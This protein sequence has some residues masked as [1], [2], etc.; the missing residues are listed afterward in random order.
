MVTKNTKKAYVVFAIFVAFVSFVI[1][2]RPLTSMAVSS[3]PVASLLVKYL[4]ELRL[5]RIRLHSM[6]ASLRRLP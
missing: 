3:S 1:S 5:P 4:T 2:R 6:P